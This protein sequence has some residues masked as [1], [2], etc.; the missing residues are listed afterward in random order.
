MIAVLYAIIIVTIVSFIFNC[1]NSLLDG[2]VFVGAWNILPYVLSFV[3]DVFDLQ[4]FVLTNTISG[5]GGMID[6]HT[7]GYSGVVASSLKQ[8]VFLQVLIVLSCAAVLSFAG[9]YIFS[10]RKKTEEIG[11]ISDSWLGYKILIPLYGVCLAWIGIESSGELITVPI[12]IGGMFSGYCL[13]RKGD[14]LRLPDIIWI[15]GTTGFSLIRVLI[16]ALE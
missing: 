7:V 1:A 13:Y 6:S 5:I 15:A 2:I 4:S 10:K 16:E 3:L 14:R 8:P 9:L 11:D 12:V